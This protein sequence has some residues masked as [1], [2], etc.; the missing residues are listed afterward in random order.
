MSSAVIVVFASFLCSVVRM[1][2]RLYSF[3]NVD[4]VDYLSHIDIC[5]HFLPGCGKF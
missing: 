3:I 5:T 4:E 2:Q 1:V